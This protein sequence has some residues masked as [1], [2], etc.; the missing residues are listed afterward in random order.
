MSPGRQPVFHGSATGRLSG[1]RAADECTPF[2]LGKVEVQR[3]RS[4]S[5]G[6]PRGQRSIMGMC[7]H[8]KEEVEVATAAVV[9]S[10]VLERVVGV[11]GGGFVV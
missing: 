3:S 5:G 9:A 1:L 6:T 7:Y 8:D 4:S 2:L 11:G 10:G